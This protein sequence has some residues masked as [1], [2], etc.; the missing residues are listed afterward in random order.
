MSFKKATK[1]QAKARIALAGVSGSGK[2]YTA[3]SLAS[4]LAPGKIAVV[5]T[6]HGSASK[7]ASG[8]PFDFDVMELT[9]PYHPDRY[10]AAIKEAV[11]DGYEIVVLDSLSHAW[12]GQGG[13]LELADNIA[14][15]K[16]CNSFVA[17][18]DVTPIQNR[19]IE[20]MLACP[21]HLVATMR[22]KQEYVI[23]TNEK[24]KA[25][26]RKL[27]LA[28][29][30]RDGM[31]YEFD[32]LAEM[33]TENTLIVQKT[34]CPDLAGAVISKPGKELAQTIR[35]WLSDGEPLPQP[36]VG[37]EPHPI[38]QKLSEMTDEPLASPETRKALGGWL[39][40]GNLSDGQRDWL[41][42]MLAD[43]RLK[44]AKALAVLGKIEASAQAGDAK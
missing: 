2:T 10:M 5:D 27:G 3:L 9:A 18:K 44:E 1:S 42:A 20:T 19:L 7:Y 24:G 33:D 16:K 4:E 22:S 35:N 25:T 14:K 31:E 29:I 26:P 6:E 13:L 39:N 23:E 30:Q 15:R 12:N 11:D 8:K 32:V 21:I 28:P 43:S 17:W 40:N 41:T 38:E 36:T 34:R 37:N